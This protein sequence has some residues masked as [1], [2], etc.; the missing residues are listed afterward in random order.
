MVYQWKTPVVRLDANVAGAEIE[1]CRDENGIIKPAS[2]VERAR[3]ETNPIHVCFEWDD[4]K[5]AARYREDQARALLRNIVTVVESHGSKPISVNAFVNIECESGRGYKGIVQV[6]ERSA[7]RAY[8]LQSAI[9]ELNVLRKKYA[10]LSELS[11][12]FDA[13]DQCELEAS[14]T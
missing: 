11:A 9:S 8:I 3:P 13:I 2:V 1:Q 6:M 5:A 14:H 10:D 12:V 4:D 7:D